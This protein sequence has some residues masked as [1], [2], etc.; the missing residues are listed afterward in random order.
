MRVCSLIT[1]LSLSALPFSFLNDFPPL[2]PPS[3]ILRSIRAWSSAALVARGASLGFSMEATFLRMRSCSA[4]TVP[5]LDSAPTPDLPA[6][7]AAAILRRMRSWS[8]VTS[9]TTRRFNGMR[10]SGSFFRRRF[11][12]LSRA[13]SPLL[14]LL[15][16]SLLRP[17]ASPSPLAAAKLD[18]MRW[19]NKTLGG[20]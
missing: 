9:D 11:L 4:A 8:S 7:P 13:S 12:R 14:L 18:K 19:R 1:S 20:W 2:F 10:S 16:S 6:F 15:C 17:F 3:R 5:L